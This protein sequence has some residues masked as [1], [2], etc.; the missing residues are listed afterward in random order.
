MNSFPG[1]QNLLRLGDLLSPTAGSFGTA[2]RQ[3]PSE[4]G[5]EAMKA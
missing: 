4:W 5:N 3:K 2:C 1:C